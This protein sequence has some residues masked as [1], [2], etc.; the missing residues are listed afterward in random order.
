[1]AW[2]AVSPGRA[3]PGEKVSRGVQANLGAIG[4]SSRVG[5]MDRG[6]AAVRFLL[7]RAACPG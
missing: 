5:P 3:G 4:W 2:S 6:A 7:Y 1:M